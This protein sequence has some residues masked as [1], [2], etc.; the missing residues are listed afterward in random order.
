MAQSRKVGQETLGPERGG[1]APLPR[2]QGDRRGDCSQLVTLRGDPGAAVLCAEQDPRPRDTQCGHGWVLRVGEG[3]GVPG[4]S[5]NSEEQ[6]R[7]FGGHTESR[8]Q[9]QMPP[10]PLG[11]GR[12]QEGRAVGRN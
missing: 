2:L 12:T 5:V 4:I 9:F 8:P 6:D 1:N 7:S 10:N 11:T 3:H